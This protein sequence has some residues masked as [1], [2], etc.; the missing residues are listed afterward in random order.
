VW[1]EAT[2]YD[3]DGVPIETF[4]S[5]WTAFCWTW[6]DLIEWL[7]RRYVECGGTLNVSIHRPSPFVDLS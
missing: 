5:E 4:T 1:L 6:K 3:E 2:F 7:E